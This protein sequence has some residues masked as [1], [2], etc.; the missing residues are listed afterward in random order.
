MA[1]QSKA[2]KGRCRGESTSG[3]GGKSPM[4]KNEETKEI[5]NYQRNEH[6]ANVYGNLAEWED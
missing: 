1:T 3:K 5:M 4:G 2:Q 6:H